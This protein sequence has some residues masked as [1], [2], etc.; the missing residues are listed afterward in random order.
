[1]ALFFIFLLLSVPNAQAFSNKQLQI[2]INQIRVLLFT[3]MPTDSL[4]VFA[5]NGPVEFRNEQGHSLSMNI[6]ETGA[7]ISSSTQGIAYRRDGVLHHSG[8]WTISARD[9]SL[10]RLLHPVAGWRYYQGTLHLDIDENGEIRVINH[11]GL[12]DYV[13]S[14]V[15]GEMNFENPE[16]L[17]VQAVIARTYALWN[18]SLYHGQEYELNDQVLNQVYQGELI[19]KPWYREAAEATAGEVLMWSNK[20]IMAVYHST[21]GGRTTTNDKVWTGNRLP[22]LQSVDDSGACSASPHYRWEL[23]VASGRLHSTLK[24][25]GFGSL[26]PVTVSG[27]DTFERVTSLSL[28]DG[29]SE[30]EISINNFRLALNRV[31]GPLAVK[32][33]FFEMELIEDTY[34]FN[35]KGLGHGVGLCQW[36]AL[37]LAEAGW[38]YKDILRFY[39]NGV[40]VLDYSKLDGEGFRLARY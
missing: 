8:K 1:M 5:H 28:T 15:G 32:S 12:E 25:A 26:E 22:Y 30:Y 2:G 9:T 18:I 17:K 37:G 7:R 14:V 10:I 11:V 38:N 23:E 27:T 34:I 39:Y 31:L 36:G 40:D 20:L 4:L 29:R 13:A 16:A 35:G 3:Q 6:G 21:C 24:P 33:S 19:F